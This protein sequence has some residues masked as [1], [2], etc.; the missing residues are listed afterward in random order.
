MSIPI[1]YLFP[2]GC[3]VLIGLFWVCV[4]IEEALHQLV[5]WACRR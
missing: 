2:L 3:L 1:V 4:L 5:N